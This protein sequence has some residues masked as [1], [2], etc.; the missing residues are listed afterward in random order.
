MKIKIIIIIP[1]SPIVNF[2]LYYN[3]TELFLEM[4]PNVFGK[5]LK[6]WIGPVDLVLV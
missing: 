4:C 1:L 2:V 3:L 5:V 6:H